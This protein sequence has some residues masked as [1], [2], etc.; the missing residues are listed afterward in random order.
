MPK[1]L[2]L[3][4]FLLSSFLSF[5]QN[6]PKGVYVGYEQNPFCYTQK[7]SLIHDT[8]PKTEKEKWYFKVTLSVTDSIISLSKIPV[9][10]DKNGIS[11]FDSTAGGYYLYN[12]ATGAGKNRRL[13]S[14]NFIS[15]NLV[16]CK[17]CKPCGSGV[18]RYIYILYGYRKSGNDII[19]DSEFEK[20][21][22]FKK[23]NSEEL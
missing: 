7:C 18:C 14:D 21:I 10:F 20:N 17:Y 2:V 3:F 22:L 11:N 6:I 5:S 19:L 9:Y 8:L 23:Q 1:F 13:I 4:T 12:I 16:N 15:G